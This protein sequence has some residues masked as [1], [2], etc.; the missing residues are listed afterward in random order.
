MTTLA[1]S[2]DLFSRMAKLDAVVRS[3]VTELASKCQQMSIQDLRESKGLHLEPYVNQRDPRART[4]RLGDN[5]RGIV[6]VP[7]RSETIVLVDVLTHEEADRWMVNNEF[8]V[9]AATGAFEI[10]DVAGLGELLETRPEAPVVEA[11]QLLYAHR[12]DKDFTA[13]GVDGDLLPLLRVLA[14]EDQLLPLLAMIPP[15]QAD[16]L[17]ALIGQDTVEDIY[18]EL[19]GRETIPEI[20]P[21]DVDTA[22]ST[23]ASQAGFHVLTGDTDL[24]E[25]LAKP[26][27]VWRTYL[28]PSQRDAAYRATYNG[29][30]RVTGGAGTGK[31]VVAMHRAKA[32]VDALDEPAGRPIL[33]TTFTRNLAQAI[34]RELVTLGGSDLADRVE[35]LNIDRLSRQVVQDA[36]GAAPGVA[37]G[38]GLRAIWQDAV[39]ELGFDYSV[40]FLIQEW[41]QVILAQGID[42]RDDY[43]QT[44]RAG[45]GVPLDRK[46]R[47]RV[48]KIVEAATGT[49]TRRRQRTYLQIAADA[50]GYLAADPVK[51][52][53]HVI[54]DEGQD[55]HETQ[56]RLIRA[57]VAEGPND[58]FIVGDSHQRI[59]DRRSSLSKVGINIRGRSRRLRINYRTTHEI[60]GWALA[61]LGEGDFDDLDAGQDPHGTAE[62]HSYL[63]GEY[64]VVAGFSTPAEMATA[65]AAQVSEWVADGIDEST[66]AVALPTKDGFALVEQALRAA[67]LRSFKL[68]KDLKFGEGVAIGTMH[69]MKG[70]EY[71]AVAVAGAGADQLPNPKAIAAVAG[72]P[73]ETA[74]E[75]QRERC[76]LY[77]AST[78][79][80][81]LLWVGYAGRPSPFLPPATATQT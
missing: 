66:I 63:H 60:L 2:K 22:I 71:V 57:A 74:R 42:S 50:A 14:D 51:P 24:A 23:P 9:N 52:Y 47:A 76:L 8:R 18:V 3:R 36:E 34:E 46:D 77:V 55:L 38:D 41:E 45:R 7:D 33:F 73:A 75:L 56:W 54:V 40:P 69:R 78:R 81:E 13:L 68:G 30:V 29:P 16:A 59:Y 17:M 15:G 39:D 31:T 43:L 67:G 20:G 28:H 53:Q 27:A 12:A 4:I 61:V 58:L 79:A 65:L 64:P 19:A 26:L 35:V 62:Y 49:M 6:M 1:V 21:D 10:V 80:R 5:H 44:S 70:L 48:W 72:D 11:Q 32:L 25:M 37:Q